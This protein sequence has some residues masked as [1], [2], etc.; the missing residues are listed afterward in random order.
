M[1]AAE[2][3]ALGGPNAEGIFV[4]R[5]RVSRDGGTVVFNW[6]GAPNLRLQKTSSLA[7]P[8]WQDVPGTLGT[9][10]FT[11]TAPVESAFYRLLRQ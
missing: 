6:S 7:E 5:L 3:S 10:T 8:N 2:L 9:G 4:R 11:E 1:S